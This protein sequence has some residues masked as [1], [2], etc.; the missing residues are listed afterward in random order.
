MLILLK[1]LDLTLIRGPVQWVEAHA[2]ESHRLQH[3]DATVPSSTIMSKFAL[4][5]S[6][7]WYPQ[8]LGQHL[9]HVGVRYIF[10]G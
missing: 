9:T 2:L 7:P 4:S 5:V 6:L 3:P 10:I 1:I 8:R